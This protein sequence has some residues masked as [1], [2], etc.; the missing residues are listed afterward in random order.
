LDYPHDAVGDNYD[1]LG[2]FQQR[3]IYYPNMAADMDPAQSAEQF[4][5][6]MVKFSGWQTMNVATLCQDVQKSGDPTAYEKYVS[7]AEEI[8]AAEGY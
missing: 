1:S 6:Q 8:C 7:Q 4:F 2:I 3:Y 5:A